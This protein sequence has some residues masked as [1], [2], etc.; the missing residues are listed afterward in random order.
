MTKKKVSTLC[1]LFTRSFVQLSRFVLAVLV[2]LTPLMNDESAFY[3]IF[4][5]VLSLAFA[6]RVHDLRL[7]F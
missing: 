1:L 2:E 5:E 6:F 4:Q 7:G 3:E